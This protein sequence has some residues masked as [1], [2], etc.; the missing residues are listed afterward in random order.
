M[1]KYGSTHPEAWVGNNTVQKLGTN[2]TELGLNEF[3]NDV[4]YKGYGLEV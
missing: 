4:Q 2:S 1:P 3:G